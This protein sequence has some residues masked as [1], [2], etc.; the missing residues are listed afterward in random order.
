MPRTQT[1]YHHVLRLIH[2]SMAGLILSGFFIGV[3]MSASAGPDYLALAAW[4]RP[5][6]IAVL[7]LVLLR[8]AIRLSSPAPALPQDMPGWQA[9]AARTAHVLLYVCMF[10]MPVLGWAMV[11][12][13]GKPVVLAP[14]TV[15]P[16]FIAADPELHAIL[17]TAHSIV[18]YSFFTLILAHLAAALHHRL[19]KQ[20][21]VFE[22]MTVP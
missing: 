16:D 14:G 11:S 3:G 7:G 8:L 21:S 10:A 12:A 2:W 5:I 15:L 13:A 22:T 4:H 20:D 9:R 18:A 6:G 1:Q 19:V 17:R